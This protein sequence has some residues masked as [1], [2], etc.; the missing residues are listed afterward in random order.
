MSVT[1]GSKLL[2]GEVGRT[3]TLLYRRLHKRGGRDKKDTPKLYT[4]I[5]KEPPL[6]N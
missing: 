2:G 5:G 1:L 3:S 4:P 6:E